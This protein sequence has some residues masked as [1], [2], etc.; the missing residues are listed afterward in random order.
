[1]SAK[2]GRIRLYLADIR[3]LYQKETQ[4]RA[5]TLVDAE[6]RYK[7]DACKTMRGKA[8]SLA[9]GLLAN[10][11]LRQSGLEEFGV[12]YD[13]KGKPRV[14][15]KRE[16]CMNPADR[17]PVYM[18]LS[19]SGDYAVCAVAPWPVGVDIQKEQPARFGMLRHLLDEEDRR[20]FLERY[21]HT[22][23]AKEAEGK[24]AEWLTGEALRE[25]FRLWTAKESYMKLTGTGMTVGF[26]NLTADLEAGI[27]RE[28]KRAHSAASWKQYRAP[29]GYYLSVCLEEERD[30]Y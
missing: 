13:E 4:D 22:E 11:A 2:G 29:E 3:P 9:A 19:H 5:R 7:A 17:E 18:S 12:R 8:A 6:R 30:G 10:Y 25:F 21:G 28:K 23:G 14:M 24:T 15:P 16:E 20:E 1:M 26:A 27:V